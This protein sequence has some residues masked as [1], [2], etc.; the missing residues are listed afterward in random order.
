MST[1]QSDG[2]LESVRPVQGAIYGGLAFIAGYILTVLLLVID[3]EFEFGNEDH[4]FELVGMIFFN[5][6]FV[7]AET[8]AAG[9]SESVNL[10]SDGSTQLPEL[11]YTLVPAVVLFLAGYRLARSSATQTTTA[12]EGATL[13]ASVVIGYLPLVA[14]G[15]VVFEVSEETFGETFSVAPEM[16][17]ALVLAGVLFPVV[18]GALG[19]YLSQH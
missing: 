5:G 9:Y 16:G 18:L 11:T 17:S 7:D 14:L 8:S 6:H 2:V 1:T 4:L 19:G 13:G 3:S 12:D 10:L 15:T